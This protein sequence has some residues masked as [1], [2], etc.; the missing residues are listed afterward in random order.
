VPRPAEPTPPASHGDATWSTAG[1]SGVAI[2]AITL[3]ALS[4]VALTAVAFERYHAVARGVGP[5]HWSPRRRP[6]RSRAPGVYVGTWIGS[7]LTAAAAN[8]VMGSADH[9]GRVTL[10]VSSRDARGQPVRSPPAHPRPYRCTFAD[11]A[12]SAALNQPSQ[13]EL[14]EYIRTFSNMMRT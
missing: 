12:P 9:A 5:R 11:L 10:H 13:A 8:A 3:A 14:E 7:G 4:A 1:Q 2:A 6:P